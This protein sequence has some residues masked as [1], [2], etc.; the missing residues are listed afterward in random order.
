MGRLKINDKKYGNEKLIT[1]LGNYQKDKVST[2]CVL[3]FLKSSLI[4]IN[5]EC[6]RSCSFKD[7]I[8]SYV[9]LLPN[10][11]LKNYDQLLS[12]DLNTVR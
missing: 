8:C 4:K 7:G 2:L 10:N 12:V 3:F 11:R 6:H 1:G 5:M 9:L